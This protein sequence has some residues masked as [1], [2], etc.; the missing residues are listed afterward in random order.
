[1][2]KLPE[3]IKQFELF[4]D[5]SLAENWDHVGLQLGNPAAEMK[6]IMTCLDVRPAVVQEAIEQ[7][8]DVIFS[9]HPLMFKPAKDLDLSNPQNQMYADLLTHGITVYSAHTNLDSANG[10]MN[11]WLAAQLG[12]TKVEKFAI[13]GADPHT[14]ESV[15]MGRIG[16]LPTAVTPSELAQLVKQR[17]QVPA[18]RLVQPETAKTIKRVAILG[19]AGGSFYQAA[20]EAGADAYVTGDLSYHVAQDIQAAE[21]VA[22]DPGH[23]IEVVA[24]R[25]LATLLT[26]W[27]Q[28]QGW[29][30][31]VL[32]STV[33]TEPF[34]FI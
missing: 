26:E 7:G 3:I 11:D 13:S 30:L 32:T 8:V 17:F 6:T 5:P 19:G 28:A 34:E 33:N 1:M 24:A 31:K 12:L 18:V 25:E 9:H 16:D 29:D 4:A 27:S 10:G 14:M 15:G 2:V 22:V 21:L 23:H 20:K